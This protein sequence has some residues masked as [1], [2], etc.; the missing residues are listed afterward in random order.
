M[1]QTVVASLG[2]ILTGTLA[3]FFVTA[4]EIRA[5]RKEIRILRRQRDDWIQIHHEPKI[6]LEWMIKED[7]YLEEELK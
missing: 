5:M 1:D 2:V 7:E 4:K 3:L 6:A